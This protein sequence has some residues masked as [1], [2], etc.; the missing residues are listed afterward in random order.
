MLAAC[1]YRKKIISLIEYIIISLKQYWTHSMI[2]SQLEA[3]HFEV[4]NNYI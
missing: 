2:E 3:K 4:I 1:R